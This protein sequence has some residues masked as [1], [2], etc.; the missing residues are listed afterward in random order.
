MSL[1]QNHTTKGLL[2]T[3]G[4]MS[5]LILAACGRPSS[6]ETPSPQSLEAN[7]DSAGIIGGVAVEASDVIA[8]STVGIIDLRYG[9]VICTGSLITNS[10]VITA[11]HCTDSNPK[12]LAI[13]FSS[14]IPET[15][16]EAGKM[17]VRQVVSGRTHPF[18]AK[19]KKGQKSNWGDIAVLKFSGPVPTGFKAARIL[20]ASSALKNGQTVTLSGFGIT[21]GR[22]ATPTS[23][24]RK[25]DVELADVKFSETEVMLDQTK[26]RG[27][28]HGDSGG[29]AFV[30]IGTELVLFGVTSRGH[31]DPMDTCLVNSI[32]TSA[33]AMLPWIKT[34]VQAL[35]KSN[36]SERIAQPIGM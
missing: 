30:K 3:W 18:W 29:P 7:E 10:M 31:K 15:Q 6:F 12:N 16:E 24:L 8:S 36:A 1:K 34:T 19:L 28:C 32:Y 11:G 22:L 25:V 17:Q 9:E 14:K 2:K 33:T 13:L 23:V 35:A 21:D 20:S 27:A 5:F 4:L 26:G